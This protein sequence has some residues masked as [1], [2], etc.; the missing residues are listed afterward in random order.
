M[1]C[2]VYVLYCSIVPLQFFVYCNTKWDDL[3]VL[4]SQLKVMHDATN[5]FQVQSHVLFNNI[6]QH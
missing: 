5:Q 2:I 3:D 6:L 1:T 4:L